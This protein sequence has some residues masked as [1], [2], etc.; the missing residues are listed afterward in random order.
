MQCHSR[1]I[2]KAATRRSLTSLIHSVESNRPCEASKP[3][4]KNI[5]KVGISIFAAKSARIE[6][7]SIKTGK[8]VTRLIAKNIVSN[9]ILAKQR[10]SLG[11]T[12]STRKQRLG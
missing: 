6:D 3:K 8:A 2:A 9:M 10:A 1:K 12:R 5:V 7:D 11:S 4:K